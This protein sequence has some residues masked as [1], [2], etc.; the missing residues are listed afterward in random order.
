MTTVC[1]VASHRHTWTCAA[2]GNCTGRTMPTASARRSTGGF[3]L[4]LGAGEGL[5]AWPMAPDKAVHAATAPALT[6][7][8]FIALQ[9]LRVLQD[10]RLGTRSRYGFQKRFRHSVQKAMAASVQ[11]IFLPCSLLRGT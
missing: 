1:P 4:G 2:A 5:G 6:S 9:A 7:V 10:K 8:Q 11:R 3:A